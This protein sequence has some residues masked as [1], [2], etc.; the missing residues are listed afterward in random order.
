MKKP[1]I[2]GLLSALG[3]G[4]YCT[5]VAGFF[6]FGEGIFGNYQGFFLIVLMLVLLVIS[7]A[8]TGSLVFGLS[9][10]W[11]YKGQTT[12]GLKVLASTLIWLIVVLAIILIIIKLF[13]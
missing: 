8:I 2:L 3:V 10:Y 7:A 13:F 6:R 1:V 4:L 12:Y 11:I 9:V 5:L